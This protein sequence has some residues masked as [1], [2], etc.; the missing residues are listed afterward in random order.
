M[1]NSNELN[2]TAEEIR[3]RIQELEDKLTELEVKPFM[4]IILPEKNIM[5]VESIIFKE[6]TDFTITPDIY[7]YYI[8]ANLLHAGK[9]Y[10]RIVFEF[11]EK[12]LI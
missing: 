5:N 7:E 8:D 12:K 9:N 1:M 4:E 11:P 2:L 10:G 6:G 3:Q